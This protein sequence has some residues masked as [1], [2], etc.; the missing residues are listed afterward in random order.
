ME[1]H[2]TVTGFK[3]QSLKEHIEV[4]DSAVAEL[5]AVY[6]RP[7]APELDTVVVVPRGRF[8][9]CLDEVT[10]W[11]TWLSTSIANRGDDQ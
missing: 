11:I 7:T 4:I 2:S 8:R 5:A 10:E 1:E 9:A 3:P 6:A